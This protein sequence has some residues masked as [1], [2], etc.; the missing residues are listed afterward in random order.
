MRDKMQWMK[1]NIIES[2][3]AATKAAALMDQF[4]K[5]YRDAGAPSGA[6]VYHR[7]IPSVGH[8]YYFSPRASEIAG[9]VLVKFGAVALPQ[10]PNLKGL[11]PITL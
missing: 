4:G 9:S 2:D 6:K 11:D 7:Q 1:V 8:T 3:V 10:S 5:S